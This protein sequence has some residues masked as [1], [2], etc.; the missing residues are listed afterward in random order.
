MPAASRGVLDLSLVSDSFPKDVDM[1]LNNPSLGA[2]I[3]IGFSQMV[4][5]PPYTLALSLVS[6]CTLHTH[7]HTQSTILPSHTLHRSLS[8]RRV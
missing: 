8:S 4:R 6:L 3:Y 1:R 2:K 5:A 7:T